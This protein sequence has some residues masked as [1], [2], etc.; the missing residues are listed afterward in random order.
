MKLIPHAYEERTEATGSKGKKVR[1]G[2]RKA[3]HAKVRGVGQQ[4]KPIQNSVRQTR[5]ASNVQTSTSKKGPAQIDYKKRFNIKPEPAYVRLLNKSLQMGIPAKAITDALR[6]LKNEHAAVQSLAKR[7][8][9]AKGGGQSSKAKGRAAVV[10]TQKALLDAYG[11]CEGDIFVKATSQGGCDVH[12]SPKALQHFG[13]G[14]EVK[15][16]ENL[17]IWKAIAQARIN[18]DK[19]KLPFAL[20]FKRANTPLFVAF[21]ANQILPHIDLTQL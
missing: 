18:A 2:I 15:C 8:G 20:F 4:H 19:K 17:N 7:R 1:P 16:S 5:L 14:I 12:L 21:D 9:R 11:L 13:F 3:S 10:L 6:A